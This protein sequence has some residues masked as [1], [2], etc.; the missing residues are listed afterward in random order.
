MKFVVRWLITAIAVAAAI[1]LIPGIQV[2]GTDNVVL[3]IA[4]VSAVLAFV[5]MFIKPI[6]QVLSCPLVIL[7]FGLFLLVVNAAMLE[8]AAW[9]SGGLLHMGIAIDGF[10]SAILGA[11]I[12]SIVTMIANGIARSNS[13]DSGYGQ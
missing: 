8:L 5:N 4:I 2:F 11:I 7:T 1:W 10:G 12:I 9:I 3:A 6:V 13:N